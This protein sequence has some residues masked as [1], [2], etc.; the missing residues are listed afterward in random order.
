MRRLPAIEL[1][2]CLLALAGSGC[3]RGASARQGMGNVRKGDLIQKVTMA[4]N[5]V[6][7]KKTLVTPPYDGYIS[8]LFVD[9][10]THV[11][12]GDPVVSIAQSPQAGEENFPLRAPFAGPVVQVLHYEGEYVE[13]GGGDPGKTITCGSTTSTS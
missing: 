2:A 12:A 6:P 13:T 7:R 4:G 8:K 11:K 3:S 1:A 5:V 10:G 9:V